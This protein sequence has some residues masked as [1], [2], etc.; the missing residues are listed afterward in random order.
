MRFYVKEIN[1]IYCVGVLKKGSK[2]MR[3]QIFFKE[4]VFLMKFRE[5]KNYKM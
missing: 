1:S 4:L 5:I 3:I 2:V